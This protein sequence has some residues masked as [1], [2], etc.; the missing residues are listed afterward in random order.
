MHRYLFDNNTYRFLSTSKDG[1]ALR[2][3]NQSLGEIELLKTISEG[4]KVY[5][6]TPYTLIEAIGLKKVPKFELHVPAKLKY[7]KAIPQLVEY[8]MRESYQFYSTH[9]D[10]S[11]ENLIEMANEQSLHTDASP[12]SKKFE[13]LCI[14]DILSYPT[15]QTYI[16]ECLS[17]D[18]LCKEDY[19]KDLI[20]PLADYLF[21]TNIY[22]CSITGLSK[23][24][25][26]K[27]H[28]Q[29]INPLYKKN[30]AIDAKSLIQLEVSMRLKKEKDYLDCDLIHL[31]CLGDYLNYEFHPVVAFT[32]DARNIIVDRIISY[33]SINA[34]YASKI[35]SDM[36]SDVQFIFSKWRPGIVVFCNKDGS[37]KDYLEVSKLPPN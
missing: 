24:R 27:Q 11:R 20:L 12:H 6:L 3:L 21:H 17:I 7:A 35:S 22:H 1:E 26:A 2:R 33:K 8:V 14:Y 31:T 37:I 28:W 13:Q 18:F 16:A 32:C 4:N 34:V 19:P 23:Y 36:K 9:P 29:Y 10:L 25:L 5:K 30:D 15:F